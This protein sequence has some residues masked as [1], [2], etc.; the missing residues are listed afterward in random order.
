MNFLLSNL[1]E[2]IL[3]V[4]QLN[5]LTRQLIEYHFPPLWIMGELSNIT[6]SPSGHAYFILKDAQAQIR[7]VCFRGTFEALG[8]V[9][10][11]GLNV[12]LHGQISLYE[13]RGE[14][15]LT[16]QNIRVA[17][18]GR[19]FE[20]FEALK[21]R[22]LHEGIF[23]PDQKKRLPK[24]PER[25]GI[26]TSP[27]AAALRDVVSTLKRRLPVFSLI[28][29]PC[30]VQ[31][32]LA[33]PQIVSAIQQ[34]QK[35]KEVDVLMICRGGGSIEDLWAFNEEIVVRAIATCSIPTITGIGHETDIT[36]SDFAADVRAATPTAAAEIIAPDRHHYLQQ[37]EIHYRSLQRALDRLLID[38]QQQLEFLKC[39]LKHPKLKINEYQQRLGY[40]EDKLK[41]YMLKYIDHSQH[42]L[43]H[44]QTQLLA[45]NPSSVL[46]RGYALV[47]DQKGKIVRHAKDVKDGDHLCIQ[48]HDS[49]VSTLAI[50][51]SKR[52]QER[53]FD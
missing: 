33:A 43:A 28:I 2:Q 34:A 41:S 32:E 17:G 50:Q 8:V 45:L 42:S 24:L 26:V 48:W 6:I 22:L 5:G 35:R 19:L 12:E 4:S 36:L 46:N 9:L 38:K 29:Y 49:Q 27:S 25:I 30:L 37:L 20:I 13:A 16:V 44:F 15:Q 3:S 39:R 51:K 52:V 53:L 18:Q 31:G 40:L 10:K 14:Y 7:C 1:N 47:L 23:D 11:Q 21:Q